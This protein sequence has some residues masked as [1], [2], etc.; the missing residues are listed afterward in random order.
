MKQ[1]KT[2]G[3]HVIVAMILLLSSCSSERA[4]LEKVAKEHLTSTFTEM[5]KDPSSVVLS[6]I[7]TVYSDD[8]LC[9]FHL[10]FSAKNGF[11][12]DVK[13]KCE[14][15]FVSSNGKNY[16]SYS[17]INNSDDGIYVTPE[18][19]EKDKKGTIY[20]TLSY[21]DGLRY[22]AAIEVNSGGREA[23]VSDG[24]DFTIPVP[25]GTGSW[26]LKAFKDEFGEEGSEKY[27]LLRGKGVF[28]NS[29][30]TNSN[31][32]AFFYAQE[33]GYGF[34]LVEYNSH[35]VKSDDSYQYRIK[36]ST[37]DVYEMTL[38]NSETS[39]QMNVWLPSDMSK[40]EEI[41]TKG[42]IITVSV[43]ERNAYSTPDTYL[44]KLNVSG[45]TE[46]VKFIGQN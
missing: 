7:E 40:L 41:L 2:I 22:L 34:K 42:G 30:T 27:L 5:A 1:V 33:G 38:F 3:L 17:E 12:I 23:G 9:I 35:V 25:T 19:Y 36:D 8:S 18:K 24:E 21:E 46:A 20:E 39:G 26:E 10:D 45:Y 15:I 6:N 32:T 29:A 13:D 44:F 16:E 28:S 14:Y 31:M 43:R 37:G 4:K 11:G